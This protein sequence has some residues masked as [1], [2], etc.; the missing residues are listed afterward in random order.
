MGNK[1]RVSE[2]TPQC[3]LTNEKLGIVDKIYAFNII[4]STARLI[5]EMGTGE[6]MDCTE[7][8]KHSPTFFQTFNCPFLSTKKKTI[9]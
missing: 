5:D 1:S 2:E 9:S 3:L 6:N 8:L 4:K 7:K